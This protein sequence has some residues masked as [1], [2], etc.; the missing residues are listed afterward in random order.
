MDRVLCLTCGQHYAR[1]AIADRLTELNP[2]I[3]LDVAVG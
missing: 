3:D 2:T 1:Q